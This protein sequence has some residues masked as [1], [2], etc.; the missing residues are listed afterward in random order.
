MKKSQPI[1]QHIIQF[2][3]LHKRTNLTDF[4]ILTAILRVWKS[5]ILLPRYFYVYKFIPMS[6]A[7]GNISGVTPEI[8]SVFNIGEYI[9]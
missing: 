5:V 2:V 6:S 3:V 8:L 1:D 9:I 7:V 4:L